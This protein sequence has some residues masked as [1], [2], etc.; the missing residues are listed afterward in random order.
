MFGSH[1]LGKWSLLGVHLFA[2]PLD[3]TSCVG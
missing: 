1:F 3:E 2:T